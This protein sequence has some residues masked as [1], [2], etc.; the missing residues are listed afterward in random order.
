MASIDLDGKISF[1][2]EA[3]RGAYISGR[4]PD[5]TRDGEEIIRSAVPIK[6]NGDTVGV[7]YGVIKLDTIGEK[8]NA[9]ASEL[10]AQLFVYDKETGKFVIDTIDTNPGEMS[11]FADREYNDGY[12]YEELRNS[13]KGYSS[14]VS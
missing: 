14:F 8:Y 6:V 3:A 2:E 4:V 12:S 5:L 9:M 7:L 13:D 10:D 11:M 1:A